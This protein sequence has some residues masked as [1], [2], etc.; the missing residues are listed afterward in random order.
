MASLSSCCLVTQR[1]FCSSID[2]CI[3][4]RF[5]RCC[6][7]TSSGYYQTL[8]LAARPCQQRQ[9]VNYIAPAGCSPQQ[10]SCHMRQPSEPELSEIAP[11]R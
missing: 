5:E 11:A 6:S 2:G 10:L 3:T 8:T 7:D 9:L 1:L 4:V